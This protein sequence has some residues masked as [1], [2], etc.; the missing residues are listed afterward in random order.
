[1][2]LKLILNTVNCFT[3]IYDYDGFS[4]ELLL[5]NIL[6]TLV[7]TG[8]ADRT[9]RVWD[10][11][12]GFCTHNFRDHTDIVQTVYF[13]PDPNRLQLFSC[14]EDNTIRIFD[15]IDSNCV[16]CFRYQTA[17]L[18]HL[19]FLFLPHESSYL[20]CSLIFLPLIVKRS[21]EFT[22]WNFSES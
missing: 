9:V 14:S 5:F 18:S 10:V 4:N 16:A 21:H 2:Y 3:S 13:H 7:A 22:D 12:K 17:S 11:A 15:L 6:G 19:F 8:S 1:M 20:I